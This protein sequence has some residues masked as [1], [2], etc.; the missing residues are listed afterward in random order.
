MWLLHHCLLLSENCG[1]Q[2]H[3]KACCAAASTPNLLPVCTAMLASPGP[4]TGGGPPAAPTD[5]LTEALYAGANVEQVLLYL[6]LYTTGMGLKLIDS[7]LR[8]TQTGEPFLLLLYFLA[9][10]HVSRR[11]LRHI[12]WPTF[13]TCTACG[14]IVPVLHVRCVFQSV[15]AACLACCCP[16]R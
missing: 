4:H 16:A 10:I 7:L 9:E 11:S 13:A 8:Y 15:V 5:S 1:S 14:R 2:Q 6:G 12:T 3:Q